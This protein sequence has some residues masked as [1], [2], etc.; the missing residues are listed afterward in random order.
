M[1]QSKKLRLG[2]IVFFAMIL[3]YG[4]GP[5]VLPDVYWPGAPDQ[6]RIKYTT[7]Y[8]GPGDFNKASLIADVLLGGRPVKTLI[9]PMGVHVSEA[10]VIYITDTALTVVFALDP[11]NED[12]WS[13]LRYGKS[14]FQKP[15]GV[16]TDGAGNVYA[17][18][19]QSKE[20][21]MFN[22]RG[23]FLKS[24][25]EDSNIDRPTGL[26]ADTKNN[27]LYVSDTAAHTIHVF[28]L[29]THEHLREVGDGRGTLEGQFNYPAHIAVG[30]NGDLVVSDTMNARVQVFDKNGIFVITFGKFGDGAGMFA[31]PKGIA[32]D[33]EGHI[34]V[35]DAA[36]NNIQIFNEDG[37]VLLAFSG[38]GKNRGAI[39]LPAGMYIDKDDYIYIADSWNERVN[40]YE[41]LGEKHKKRTEE[42]VTLVK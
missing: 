11:V 1:L 5:V 3:T 2:L 24:I 19:A 18:D 9:K 25:G 42:G 29:I 37:E 4:C 17:T 20:I 15:I 13:L 7:Q 39:I 33:S 6:P 35:A 16:T 30:P 28:D 31:R 38:Y 36:F 41:F 40:V 10:G 26:A 34:Y 23:N 8:V 22:N 21:M 12:A 27:L 32:V 14:P